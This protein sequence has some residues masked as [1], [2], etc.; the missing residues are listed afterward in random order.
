MDRRQTLTRMNVVGIL[1]RA[2]KVELLRL[3]AEAVPTPAELNDEDPQVTEERA[4]ARKLDGE[5]SR[6][7]IAG[8][9]R[10]AMRI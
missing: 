3:Q 8:E 6:E 1:M 9:G 4:T 10:I 5:E 2:H 7:R